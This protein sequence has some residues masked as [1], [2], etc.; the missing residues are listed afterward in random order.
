MA[1]R[2]V[3][4]EAVVKL[5]A[6]TKGF[7]SE[8][9]AAKA[10]AES[11][12][13][14]LDGR[15][16]IQVD[17]DAN[18]AAAQAKLAAL[19]AEIER[20][21]G[22]Y[23]SKYGRDQFDSY[24]AK[25]LRDELGK[26]RAEYDAVDSSITSYIDHVN[27][28]ADAYDRA[29]IARKR[30][31]DLTDKDLNSKTVQRTA[32]LTGNLKTLEQLTSAEWDH[33][34]Q[35]R[36]IAA[37]EFK[38]T[39]SLT[40][41][42]DTLSKSRRKEMQERITAAGGSSAFLKALE[43]ENA[44]LHEQNALRRLLGMAEIDSGNDESERKKRGGIWSILTAGGSGSPM[45]TL[46]K[47]L[48]EPV[49]VGPFTASIRGLTVGMT[50]LGH[51]AAS[52]VGSLVAMAGTV[53]GALTGAFTVGIAGVMGFGQAFLGVRAVIA[54][55]VKDLER[56]NQATDAYTTAVAKYGKGSDQ[57][58]DAQ[59]RLNSVLGQMAPTARAAFKDYTAAQLE[60]AN[61]TK[62]TKPM[63]DRALASTTKTFRALVPSFADNTVNT[64]STASNSVEQ[65][66][67]YLRREEKGGN[68]FLNTTFKQANLALGPLLGGIGRLGAALGNIGAS[69][70]RYL[71][72]L[73]VW[74]DR[75]MRSFLGSTN[76]KTG[77]N[78]TIDG[79][80]R[81]FKS[82]GRTIGAAT[83]LL[84]DFFGAGRGAGRGL[85]DS[86]TGVFNKW[87]KFI[88][89]TKGRNTIQNF[90]NGAAEGGKLLANVVRSI[91]QFFVL[92][93]TVTAPLAIGLAKVV[94]FFLQIAGQAM[95]IDGVTRALQSMAVGA[96][97]AL[98]AFKSGVAIAAIGSLIAKIGGAITALRNLRMAAILAWAASTGGMS[99]LIGGLV[100][101][102]VYLLRSKSRS[103]TLKDSLKKLKTEAKELG[104][105]LSDKSYQ[106][107]MNALQIKSNSQQLKG[108]KPN[109]V[110]A[111]MLR[112]ENDRLRGENKK[113]DAEI[114][115]TRSKLQ[116]NAKGQ[117]R[118]REESA[119]D[120]FDKTITPRRAG[121]AGRNLLTDP[122][123]IKKANAQLERNIRLQQQAR[124]FEAG[125]GIA[126]QRLLTSDQGG[127]AQTTSTKLQQAIGK[128]IRAGAKK[129]AIEIALNGKLNERQMIRE[130]NRIPAVR[131]LS[132]QVEAS[133]IRAGKV[134]DAFR[135]LPG[136]SRA[137]GGVNY[138]TMAAASGYDKATALDKAMGRPRRAAMGRFNEPTLL[139]GE[140][141]VP[142]YVIATNPAY[143]AQNKRYLAAAAK[144]L[145]MGV[146]DSS[147]LTYAAVGRSPAGVT[148][149][150]I[151][152]E[153]ALRSDIEAGKAK[154]KS[155]R[156]IYNPLYEKS[157]RQTLTT[158]E[159]RRAEKALGEISKVNNSFASGDLFWARRALAVA[160]KISSHSDRADTLSTLMSRAK[161][162]GDAKGFHNYRNQRTGEL[163]W[164]IDQYRIALPGA[165]PKRKA[166]INKAIA[167]WQTDIQSNNMDEFQVTGGK[168]KRVE[169]Q[170]SALREKLN[171]DSLRRDPRAFKKD[172]AALDKLLRQSL[173]FYREALKGA[174][175][176]EKPNLQSKIYGLESEIINN[177]N[178]AYTDPV[179]EAS[180]QAKL[181]RSNALLTSAR[182]EAAISTA[183]SNVAG[184]MMYD[185]ESIA[186][187]GPGG[188]SYF[189]G[190]GGRTTN[191]VVVNINTLH[192]G[193]PN[194][195]SA[196]ASAATGGLDLQ[197]TV[198]SPRSLVG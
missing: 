169:D 83:N 116:A 178:N 10:K 63:L 133:P 47:I 161:N 103:D 3:V 38:D 125:Q 156:D 173:A 76:N 19:A 190:R 187:G 172:K 104:E 31:S 41:V 152:D 118:N 198:T 106:R 71:R 158:A 16:R 18:T 107:S 142:E 139:V 111:Q 92:I 153:V 45:E 78:R 186:A 162:K 185:S 7:I 191:P 163:E 120:S 179:A 146:W 114:L 170:T 87:D 145:G 141:N 40:Q 21:Q 180:L 131:K 148:S 54:P 197:G 28:E 85:F 135:Q 9:E 72:P 122:D 157:R 151:F 4:G 192:P 94:G 128:A 171:L 176:Y 189:S 79:L 33:E 183:F 105:A 96:A 1:R 102:G 182:N 13:R 27:D 69:A 58:K 188:S 65:G 2:E 137:E 119:N 159:R 147:G 68:G 67:G 132:I 112:L 64:V 80:V 55:Y 155:Q 66:M 60:F 14:S 5:S 32:Q 44:A 30:L 61:R 51:I 130:L 89:S 127:L 82:V 53:G 12:L 101:L 194:T 149:A 123:Y 35:R 24:G 168:Q 46:M 91:G 50:Y 56:A 115:S 165:N 52:V 75:A 144:A 113:L 174:S 11:T 23:K 74:F 42:M 90:F 98:A 154:S 195:L 73:T 6:D 36:S 181:E 134:F 150:A 26:L 160:D 108:L 17:V 175:A 86:L 70:S 164:L 25:A 126:S 136:A 49:K 59:I 129:Q 140:E 22:S 184:S 117:T 109:S 124:D 95:K 62:A 99:V 43:K 84:L 88:T 81:D 193:D 143:R 29:R 177:R 77:L 93:T 20:V 48:K 57:A 39:K 196:V 167:G 138:G 166:A 34:Q 15:Q 100:T 121:R 37:A 97:F 8:L 110:E